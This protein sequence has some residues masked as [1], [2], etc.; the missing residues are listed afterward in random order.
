MITPWC[1]DYARR[2]TVVD[3]S[4]LESSSELFRLPADKSMTSTKP[5]IHFQR[6][7]A[8]LLITGFAR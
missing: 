2:S 7:Q 1:A 5:G 4:L 8:L 3:A 6:S